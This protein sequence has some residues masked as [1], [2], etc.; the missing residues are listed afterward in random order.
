MSFLKKYW[1]WI[2]G[3]G[4]ALLALYLFYWRKNGAKGTGSASGN[5]VTSTSKT[6]KLEDPYMRGDAVCKL[7]K[8]VRNEL[9]DQGKDPKEYLIYDCIFGPST[10]EALNTAFGT[11]TASVDEL[12]S[13][14]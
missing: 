13:M 14:A 11:K 2:V 1:K 10:Q 5:E 6:L 9:E 3:V 8:L 4:V 7:Q 12:K